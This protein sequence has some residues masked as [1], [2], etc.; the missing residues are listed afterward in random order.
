MASGPVVP[1]KAEVRTAAAA[2]VADP[3]PDPKVGVAPP[4]A[5]PLLTDGASVSV[6]PPRSVQSSSVCKLGKT[7][8]SPSVL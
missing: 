7:D 2:A 5:L 1:A 4:P 6:S 3:D 8:V